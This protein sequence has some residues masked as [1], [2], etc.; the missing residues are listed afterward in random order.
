MVTVTR[1][2]E[3]E[4]N[5]EFVLAKILGRN[6]IVNKNNPSQK[7][8]VK[9]Y[10]RAADDMY[11]A[12]EQNMFFYSIFGV[13]F[14]FENISDYHIVDFSSTHKIFLL[15]SDN[16]IY[17]Y[18]IFCPASDTTEPVINCIGNISA[19]N[20]YYMFSTSYDLALDISAIE[21]T[22]FTKEFKASLNLMRENSVS[23]CLC[24]KIRAQFINSFASCFNASPTLFWLTASDGFYSMLTTYNLPNGTTVKSI[25]KYSFDFLEVPNGLIN[26]KD[27]KFYDTT[28]LKEWIEKDESLKTILKEPPYGYQFDNSPFGL[29][30]TILLSKTDE[31]KTYNTI[32]FDFANKTN[33][34]CD[35]I[36]NPKDNVYSNSENRLITRK[37][38]IRSSNGIPHVFIEEKDGKKVYKV[39]YYSTHMNNLLWEYCDEEPIIITNSHKGLEYVLLKSKEWRKSKESK[40][41]MLVLNSNLNLVEAYEDVTLDNISENGVNFDD[42]FSVEGLK[43]FRLHQEGF[44]ILKSIRN[45]KKKYLFISASKESNVAFELDADTYQSCSDNNLLL[46]YITQKDEKGKTVDSIFNPRTSSII[47]FEQ[48]FNN[49]FKGVIEKGKYIKI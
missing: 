34:F 18:E 21:L 47:P 23:M 45:F 17:F 32:M 6:F 16:N 11:K 41:V 29:V 43:Y 40:N 38:V 49:L 13:L 35:E 12:I 1:L 26:K 7:V 37:A 9:D 44:F 42:E 28:K 20:L 8:L 19:P 27:G 10:K 15:L 39:Y 14:K 33:A 48:R 25:Y 24:P 4:Q 22:N 5:A 3:E 36:S 2:F 31:D 30:L 46:F